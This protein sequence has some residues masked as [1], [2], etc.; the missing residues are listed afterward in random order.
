MNWYIE[1]LKKY[2]VFGG[3]ARR[4]EYWYFVLF[5]IIATII[6]AVID[7]VTGTYDPETG[8]GVLGV[9]YA[10]GVLI[11]S[12]AVSFRRLHDTGR[13]AWWLLIALIPLIGG[14]VLLVFLAQDSHEEE[15]EYGIS[16]KLAA[17]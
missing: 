17:I 16:P 1:V 8:M 4:Q 14:I 3:R 2:A 12:I 9:I 7:G 13:S 5:N 6:L 11:P 15:N 10:L